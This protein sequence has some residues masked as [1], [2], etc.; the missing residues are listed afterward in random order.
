MKKH[1]LH[2]F[3][4]CK[5]RKRDKLFLF[6]LLF[7]QSNIWLSAQ[8]N[9]QV[10]EI[11]AG[12][13]GTD[14][15][16]DWFEIENT[17]TTAWVSGTD[18]DLFYDDESASAADADLIQGLVDIQPGETVIVLIAGDVADVA[19]FTS[20]WGAAIDLTG[21]E[22]GFSDGAGLGGSGDA[23]NIWL[24]DPT[25]STPIA[26]GAYPATDTNDGQSYDVELAAFSTIGNANGAVATLAL[27]GSNGDVPNIGSPGNQGPFMADP[28]AP[29]LSGDLVNANPFLNITTEGPAAVCLDLNDATDP[30]ASTGIAL[31]LADLDTPLEDITVT[32]TS[33]DQTVVPDQNLSI[34]GTA[35][36]RVLRLTALAIGYTNITVVATDVDGKMGS[37]TITL[38]VSDATIDPATTR[39]HVGTSDGSTA[40]VIDENYMWVGD[41]ENQTIRLYDRTQ[42]GLPLKSI[43]FDGDLGSDAEVDIEGSFRNGDQIFWMGSQTNLERSVLF[44]TTESGTGADANLTFAGSYRTLRAD[45]IN[46]DDNNLHGLGASFYGLASGFEIEGLAADPNSSTGALVA[47]RG[48]LFDGKTLILPVDNFQSIVTLNPVANSAT[49]GTPILMNLGGRTIRSIECNE[50]GCVIIGGPAG[51]TNDFRLFTWSGQGMDEPELRAADLMAQTNLSSFE[52]IVGIPATPFLGD[53]GDAVTLQLL[54][55]TGTFNYYN[56]GNEAKDL[57]NSEWKKFRTELVQLDT[58]AILPIANPNDL[59]I[60]EIMQNPSVVADSEG[61]W[62]EIYNTTNASIDINGWTITDA[63]V[64]SHV[65]DNGGPLVIEAGAYFV[66]GNSANTELNGNTPVDYA[67]SD[68]TL[69]NGADEIILI[70]S[71]QL[72]VDRVEW[73]GGPLFPDPNG[74]S[75]SLQAPNLNNTE[76]SNWCVAITAY[77]DGD[78]GTPGADNDC[79]SLPIADLRVTEIWPGQDG[80][81]LT[82]DWFEITNFGDVPWVSGVDAD[83]YY[84]DDSQDPAVADLINGIT[85][86]QAGESVIVM[87]DTEAAVAVFSDVWSPDYDLTDVEIGWTD[88]SGLGQGG[89]GVT[90]F[91]GTPSEETVIDFAAYPA[92]P[93]G[94]S[95]DLVLE[96]F[97]EQ[98]S[99]MEE[100]GT[101]VA[102]ATTAT[103]GSSGMESAIGSPGNKGPVGALMSDLQIT[104]I[105]PGQAGDDLTSDWFEI[106]NVGNTAWVSGVDPDL[107]YD[108]ESASAGDADLI[109]G[110]TEL[111]PGGTAIVLLT[112]DTSDITAFEAVWSPVISLEGVEIAYTDGAGLGGGGDAVTLWAGDPAASSPIDT[113]SYP[114][115]DLFDG[116]SYDV[117]LQ[118]FSVV[119]NANGAV[120]TVALGGDAADVPNV[121]SPGNGLAV[122]TVSGLEITEIFP[123]Q[124]GSDLTVDWFEIKNTGTA[125]WVAG[126]NPDLYY[127]DESAA[128]GDADPIMGLTELQPG[129]TAIILLTGDTSDIT[130]FKTV[131]SPVISLAGIEIGYTDGAGLGGGGD[132]VTLWAGD[133][134]MSSPIDTASYPDTDLFDGQSYDVE[135]Q[136]FSVVANAN[137]AVQTIALGGD[138]ADVPNIG[139]PGN[140]LAVP[141]VSGLEITEIFPGQA[142]TDLTA[143][144]FEIKNIGTTA[145]VAGVDPDLYYDDESAS[146][147]DADLIM[148]LTELQPGATAIVVLTGDTSDV[149]TFKTVWDPVTILDG[150]EI[151]YTDGAGLGGGGDAVTLW[152]GDPQL[153]LPIDTASYPDTDLFDGQSYDSELG[154][155]SVVANANDAVQT[156][157]LGG[158]NADVPNIGSPGNQGPVTSVKNALQEGRLVAYPNP[159]NGWVRIELDVTNE[160]E[161]LHVFDVVGK[162]VHSQ[163]VAGNETIDLDLSHLPASMYYLQVKGKEW[164]AIEKII[165]N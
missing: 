140:G 162:L 134:T 20:V 45:I 70:A 91:L 90:L 163:L 95:Y 118:A 36:N 86:I 87:V 158:E 105:F 154:M 43:N 112:G 143:D 23:V 104:E 149:T 121:G 28:N 18:P 14:L 165:K 56:D 33:S 78:L 159:T 37:Y 82:A 153:F 10:T 152:A 164:I 75:M 127:D 19:T 69:A 133:P 107:Y 144:W 55:D 8:V 48:P 150:I 71:D 3:S 122:P 113:A 26:M 49:F 12:Q 40:I 84:D 130:E 74:A 116:Q 15:T 73:D 102:V 32:A 88:G 38:A 124:G 141:M 7:L 42:S 129:A 50:N 120:Q 66:L 106:K 157:L 67:Y 39:F 52:G 97:S 41:D 47:F 100:L 155:F 68:F 145:W 4:I 13:A 24:G 21:I 156:L 119:A 61:E 46:W 123:G 6:L 79:P 115:T 161:Q 51:Q 17:G 65:I 22:V 142:S 1:L 89:D 94:P 35:G 25:A 11:F 9:L 54:V 60:T 29:I 57:P 92:A 96:A 114:D 72:E 138:N 44:S 93:S 139:S 64:D 117:E 151:G 128:A 135:L 80:A 31:V 59:V 136:A 125:A 148:G 147:D 146:A 63:D 34:E 131:W 30:V 109:M 111:Q 132:A 83:L 5:N 126:E 62:F 160:M 77:G 76:A 99:G 16:A 98:G 101:N 27:G 108:D 110:L 53:N 85:D 103:A 2:L 137:G 58:V 81:D